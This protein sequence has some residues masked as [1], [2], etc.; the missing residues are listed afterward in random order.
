[1]SRDILACLFLLFFTFYSLYNEY[2]VVEKCKKYIRKKDIIIKFL[3]ASEDYDNCLEKYDNCN[4][5]KVIYKNEMK[6][7]D[8]AIFYR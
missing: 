1:M 7:M 3:K 4:M 5:E 2:L 8:E 6:K